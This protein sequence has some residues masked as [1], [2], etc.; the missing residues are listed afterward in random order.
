MPT[1]DLTDE[2]HAAV[3]AAVSSAQALTYG[4]QRYWSS[5][6]QRNSSRRSSRRPQHS[7]RTPDQD[8]PAISLPVGSFSGPR[9]FQTWPGPS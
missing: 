7:R 5:I 8:K 1:I 2:E 3:T 4:N 9:N 6:W